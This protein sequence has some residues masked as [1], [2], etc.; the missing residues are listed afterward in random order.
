M[1]HCTRINE[2]ENWD[3]GFWGWKNER[4]LVGFCTIQCPPLSFLQDCKGTTDIRDIHDMTDTDWDYVS[5]GD[6][7]K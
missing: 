3:A 6:Q 2:A 1:I 7:K 4:F 5:Q